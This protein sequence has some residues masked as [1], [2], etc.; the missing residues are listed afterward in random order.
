MIYESLEK[1]YKTS[2]Y[3]YVLPF[4]KEHI[5]RDFYS[6]P[7]FYLL[8]ELKINRFRSG[9]PIILARHYRVDIRNMIPLAAFFELTFTTAMA[10][11]DY[12]DN[13][14]YREGLLAAHKKFGIKRTLLACDYMNHKMFSI[15][16]R[17]LRKMRLP[18]TTR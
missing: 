1:E 5:E 4:I 17:E 3:S 16:I 10:Q 8:E 6:A 11:D 18:N 12:Y 14:E 2:F 13:D 7:I 9:L 15:L